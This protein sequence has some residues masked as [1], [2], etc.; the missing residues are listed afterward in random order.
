MSFLNFAVGRVSKT[1]TLRKEL[2]CRSDIRFDLITAE[3]R[4]EIANKFVVCSDHA[5]AAHY[6]KRPLE[7]I[8]PTLILLPESMEERD[9][10]KDDSAAF[11]DFGDFEDGYLEFQVFVHPDVFARI[12]QQLDTG[13][14]PNGVQIT[15]H[16]RY[17]K[18]DH[19]NIQL[20]GPSIIWNL[21]D[22]E[23]HATAAIGSVEFRT[24]FTA[25]SV[26]HNKSI[27]RGESGPEWGHI[28]SRV[29]RWLVRRW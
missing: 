6:R 16:R 26:V 1:E 5:Y 3:G 28:I 22:G 9:K 25:P 21:P 8:F 20:G 4:L 14:L 10:E 18:R 13:A 17:Y 7:R 11:A 12:S 29:L 27:V 23:D 2:E 19:H 15:F 24:D